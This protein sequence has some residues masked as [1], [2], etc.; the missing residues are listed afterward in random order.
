MNKLKPIDLI[1]SGLL[2]ANFI[3]AIVNKNVSAIFGW[4]CAWM[5]H[6]T[7]LHEEGKI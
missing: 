6:F 3:F 4:L 1:I 7:S 2:M 5:W